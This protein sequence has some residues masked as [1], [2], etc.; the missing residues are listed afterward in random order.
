[1]KIKG[2]YPTRGIVISLFVAVIAG[3]WDV[4]WHGA[5]G[6]DSFWEPPHIMLYFSVI[7]AVILGVVG[8]IQT[9]EKLLKRLVLVLLVIPLAGPFDEL[10]HRIFGIEDLSSPLIVWSPPHLA[11]IFALLTSFILLLPLL[12]RDAKE[13]QIIFGAVVFSS[14]L[15]LLLFLFAPFQPEG[16]WHL[17]GFFGTFFIGAVITGVL[18][19]AQRWIPHPAASLLTIAFFLMVAAIGFNEEIAEG[20]TILPHE[21][22]PAFLTVFSFMT[23]GVAVLVT[24]IW[25]KKA[26]AGVLWSVIIYSFSWIFFEPQFTYTFLQGVIAIVSA[27]IGSLMIVFILQRRGLI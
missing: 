3:I 2:L 20:V 13:W 10:W 1:M 18:I 27:T 8:Y 6:R 7:L 15:Q 11:I 16:A 19:L 5:M 25:W 22:P 12:R 26:F 21:H 24:K 9:K 14:I 4:W 17:A 23:A